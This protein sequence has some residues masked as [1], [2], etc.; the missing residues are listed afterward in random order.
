[1][2]RVL[3]LPILAI[4]LMVSQAGAAAVECTSGNKAI[5]YLCAW[6]APT[7]TTNCWKLSANPDSSQTCAARATACGAGLRQAPAGDLSAKQ[8]DDYSFD[9][10]SFATVSGTPTFDPLEDVGEG[11]CKN[12]GTKQVFCQQPWGCMALSTQY[13]SIGEGESATCSPTGTRC[14]CT[15][16]INDCPAGQLYTDVNKTTMGSGDN[17]QCTDYSGVPVG[18]GQPQPSSS[19]GGSSSS[20]DT[21]PIISYNKAP[22]TGLNVV[23]FAR[24]LQIASD[25]DA[26]VA[27]FDMHGKQVFGQKVFSG[28]TTIS[29]VNQKTG[30]YYAVVK[31]GSQK[32]TVKVILK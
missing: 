20:G 10:T 26:T 6:D 1:M 32:Q 13:S 2:K 17:K 31:S 16:L 18:G 27:L 29:L 25:K 14:T 24:N 21:D 5:N 12:G 19:S 4:G 30:V 3:L 9:C 8:K 7:L 11:E 23:S 28:T 15:Q 22:V